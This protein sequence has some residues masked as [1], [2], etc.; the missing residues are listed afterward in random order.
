MAGVIVFTPP[1][2][3]QEHGVVVVVGD[4][5]NRYPTSQC[6]EAGCRTRLGITE[7][8]LA[9][10]RLGDTATVAFSHFTTPNKPVNLP[11]SLK[12]FTSAFKALGK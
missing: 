5:D 2:T 4:H 8:L 3:S 9:A 7:E 1:G 10:F 12:G 11:L 6:T